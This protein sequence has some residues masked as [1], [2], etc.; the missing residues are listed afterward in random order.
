M[1][2]ILIYVCFWPRDYLDLIFFVIFGPVSHLLEG[3]A[4]SLVGQ[5][6]EHVSLEIGL[7]VEVLGHILHLLHQEVLVGDLLLWLLSFL[8][9]LTRETLHDLLSSV[10]KSLYLFV[11]RLDVGVIADVV[12]QVAQIAHFLVDP[13]AYALV[14]LLLL[15]LEHVGMLSLIYSA[16]LGLLLLVLMLLSMRGLRLDG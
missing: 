2:Q 7:L 5:L 8:L 14:L 3:Y 1:V 4:L 13:V 9:A 10:L 16:S 12:I 6:G 15:L 11:E